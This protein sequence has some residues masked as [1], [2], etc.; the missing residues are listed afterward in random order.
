VMGAWKRRRFVVASISRGSDDRERIG[1]RRAMLEEVR[2][3][4]RAGKGEWVDHKD[5]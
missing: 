1:G 4:R 3:S 2:S 5:D